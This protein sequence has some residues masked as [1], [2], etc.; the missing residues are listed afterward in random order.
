MSSLAKYVIA[1]NAYQNLS[2]PVIYDFRCVGN[3]SF[4]PSVEEIRRVQGNPGISGIYCEVATAAPGADLDEA[5]LAVYNYRP[6]AHQ[7]EAADSRRG[8]RKYKIPR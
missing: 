2:Q 6:E 5:V 7:P 8:Q 4:E 3:T 1:N